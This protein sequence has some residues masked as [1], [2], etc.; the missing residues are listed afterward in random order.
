M[1]D[2]IEG[3]VCHSVQSIFGL[4]PTSETTRTIVNLL[5]AGLSD[6]VSIIGLNPAF[7][8]KKEEKLNEFWHDSAN[9]EYSIVDQDEYEDL[10]RE[11]SIPEEL[12]NVL[13]GTKNALVDLISRAVKEPK[14]SESSICYDT[15]H[16]MRDFQACGYSF[17]E[18]CLVAQLQMR[19]P[20]QFKCALC[21]VKDKYLALVWFWMWL[22]HQCCVLNFS[23][24]KADVRGLLSVYKN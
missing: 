21:R 5:E 8:E 9:D 3:F 22:S 13:S 24:G 11:N 18:E 10:G 23:N 7:L 19:H 12:D 20:T 16:V 1:Y 17:G 2:A 6:Y 14:D 4:G 15:N